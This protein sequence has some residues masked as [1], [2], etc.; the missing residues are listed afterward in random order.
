[1]HLVVGHRSNQDL[2]INVPST[3]PSADIWIL[4]ADM[5]LS[6]EL[7]TLFTFIILMNGLC[8]IQKVKLH[9]LSGFINGF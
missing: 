8:I 2:V 6:L 9:F 3:L 4:I 5:G 1:M 7:T